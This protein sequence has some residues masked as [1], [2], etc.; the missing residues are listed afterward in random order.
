MIEMTRVR[1]NFHPRTR[2]Q[3]P[4]L[5]TEVNQQDHDQG[6]FNPLKMLATLLLALDPVTAFTPSSSAAC[7][8]LASSSRSVNIPTT[9]LVHGLDSSRETFKGTAARLLE[10]GYPCLTLD[11][12]GHGESPLGDP[13]DFTA[14]AL[15][16][17]VLAAVRAHGIDRA[18]LV[19]HSMGGRV[20][21]RAAAIDAA[22]DQP[23][24]AS[25]IIEDM[26]LRTRAPP[27]SRQW[28]RALE[29]FASR[30]FESWEAARENLLPWYDGDSTRVDGWRGK[31]VRELPDGTWW[32]DIN[33][34]AQ[35]LARERILASPD[36]RNAWDE[37]SARGNALPFSVHVWYADGQGSP[38]GTV[39][40]LS[41]AGSIE[42]MQQRLPAARLRFFPESGHSIHNTASEAF[43]EALREAI[44]EAAKETL[45]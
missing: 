15:G 24:L 21:M 37:L 43:D 1:C 35:N 13:D 18:V 28:R 25:V 4:D 7:I 32:S 3:W 6:V 22:S 16:E 20:A 11:L 17:D 8:S 34:A 9:V 5:C 44:T 30:R 45:Q 36:G 19:G 27:P 26:D 39:V 33:P 42:D 38:G 41:G 29:Q 14:S 31:R 2:T 12:R 10:D 23:L 40:K